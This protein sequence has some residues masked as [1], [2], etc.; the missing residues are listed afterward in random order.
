MGWPYQFLE[1]TSDEKNRRR[2]LLDRYALYAQVSILIPFVLYAV[3]RFCVWLAHGKGWFRLGY[4]PLGQ[5]PGVAA[6][7]RAKY[8]QSR[9]AL[10]RRRKVQWWLE[11]E[12]APG[13]GLRGRWIAAIV[14]ALW[15]L[16]L[17]LLHTGNDYIH[18]TKRFGI[19]A[20]SQMP[21]LFLL[22]MRTRFSPLTTVLRSSHEHMIHWHQLC[23]RIVMTLIGL[24][25]AWYLNFYLQKG[26]LRDRLQHQHPLT[27]LI[28][29]MMICA[30][31]TTSL[32]KVRRWSYR[33]FIYCHISAGLA[34]WLVLLFHAKPLRLYAAQSL[35]IYA[36]DRVLRY[37]DTITASPIITEIPQT[38]LLKVVLPI[39][40]RKLARFGTSPGQHIY[41][42]FPV[43]DRWP[44]WKSLLSNPFTVADISTGQI[45]LVLRARQGPVTRMLLKHAG[46]VKGAPMLNIEGPYGGFPPMLEIASGV[47][48]VLLVAGGSEQLGDD[49]IH[50]VWA[51]KSA[52]EAGWTLDSEEQRSVQRSNI[53]IYLTGSNP[54]GNYG[55]V[56]DD[57]GVEMNVLQYNNTAISGLQT[58]TGRPDLRK[59]VDDMMSYRT[60][61][62]V[63]VIYCGPKNMGREL[64]YHAG[65]WVAKGRHVKWHEEC[66]GW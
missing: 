19:I 42:S 58:Q 50:F 51:L 2:E 56:S 4:S 3:A 37:Y 44:W 45:T 38:N 12:F 41:L 64:R 47:D 53:S 60:E 61:E 40:P 55:E 15:L 29:L 31:A 32:E 21:L 18:I 35:A 36:V 17:C 27:G 52:A 25:G 16:V 20:A 5:L 10:Q 62:R 11:D 6:S 66:F 1:L 39:A 13:W 9:T 26:I 23:A 30:I 43:T 54:N 65:R 46:H 48:R 28:A 59:L 57:N 33:I 49:R 63:A 14:W 7:T 24:H 8:V 34:I 22:S